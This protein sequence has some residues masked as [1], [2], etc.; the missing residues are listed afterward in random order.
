LVL[1]P[2]YNAGYLSLLA[3]QADVAAYKFAFS[4]RWETRPDPATG[5]PRGRVAQRY[6]LRYYYN[7]PSPN[8]P[9]VTVAV[10]DTLPAELTFRSETHTPAMDWQRQGN[11]LAWQTASP[12]RP[13]QS[14]L[15]LI[16][17]SSDSLS[18]GDVITNQAEISAGALHYDLQAASQIPTFAPIITWPGNGEIYSGTMQVRGAAQAGVTVTLYAD[19]VLVTQTLADANGVFTATYVYDGSGAVT[20]KA[21]ACLAGPGCSDDSAPVTLTPPLSFWCPQRSKW[22][23]TMTSGPAVGRT[24]TFPFRNRAGLFSTQDRVSLGIIGTANWTLDLYVGNMPGTSTPPHQVRVIVNGIVYSPTT[25]ISGL[26]PNYQ[27]VFMGSQNSQEVAA[28]MCLALCADDLACEG[29]CKKTI[30]P[31][32]YIFDVTKGLSVT[33][34]TVDT[35][36]GQIIPLAVTNTIKGVTVT[37]MVSIQ[38]SGGWVPWPAQL[39]DNQQNPQV[40]GDNGYFA[41]F[42]PPGLYY[43]QVEGIAGYQAWRSPDVQVISQV[44]HVNVP[45]TPWAVGSA[46]PVTLAQA[47]PSPAVIT[48]PLGSAVE[49]TSELSSTLPMEQLARLMDDPVLRPLSARNPLSDTLGWDGGMMTPGQVYRRQFIQAGTYTYTDGTGHTG[50]VVVPQVDQAITFNPLPD[51]ALGDPPFALAAAASSGLPVTFTTGSSVCAVSGVTVTLTDSGQ[52]AITAHQFGNVNYWSAPDV[53]QVFKVWRKVY[54][55]LV[56]KW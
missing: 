47:G 9:D 11:T 23:A 21:Q 5:N 10:T 50:Q 40:T 44:V 26:A 39:Y 29:G 31:D 53:T 27:C 48:T 8:P 16:D 38:Q 6:L 1:V 3:V 7:N 22:T 41:F 30:D 18:P 14:G 32:G 20:L 12:V 25:S 4:P 2:T 49:W 42:T 34:S 19:N 52:C 35:V 37:A 13:G 51:K 24:L 45:Y 33:A 43:L 55:P 15:V 28:D 17:A 46:S 56:I 36:T 54:L